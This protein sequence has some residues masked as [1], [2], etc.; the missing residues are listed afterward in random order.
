M[1][2]LNNF[3]KALIRNRL[4]DGCYSPRKSW[5]KEDKLKEKQAQAE[6]ELRLQIKTTK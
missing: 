2:H 1:P 6:K 3:Q 4:H 5:K